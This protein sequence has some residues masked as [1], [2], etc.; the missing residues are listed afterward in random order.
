MHSSLK[1]HVEYLSSHQRYKNNLNKCSHYSVGII[2]CEYP[3]M[4]CEI[5]NFTPA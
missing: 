5:G 3:H 4:S 2:M 1:E